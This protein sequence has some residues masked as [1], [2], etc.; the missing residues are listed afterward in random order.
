MVMQITMRGSRKLIYLLFSFLIH[1]GVSRA[2]TV[3]IILASN[4]NVEFT[5]NSVAKLVNGI[6]LPNAVTVNI[7]A[8]GTGWDLYAGSVTS[9][10]G[11]WDNAQYY[12]SSGDGLPPVSLLQMRVH[13]LSNTPLISGYVPM[14][15]VATSTLDIIGNHNVVDADINCSDPSP[16]GTNTAG[17]YTTDPQCYQ[18]K[19]DLKI[20][21]GVSYRP[22]IYTL[23]IEFIV[24]P[25]L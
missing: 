1:T 11:T 3:D 10:A 18:F 22:G 2:Q 12:T 23:Q 20:V 16:V 25:D 4:P 5:F 14:Q 9:T 24:A 8:V 13:N 6:V 19:V 15:D 21:P 7:E 17:S